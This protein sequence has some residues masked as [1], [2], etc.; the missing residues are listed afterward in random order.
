MVIKTIKT[1]NL[2]IIWEQ[3]DIAVL[4]S[5]YNF[6]VRDVLFDLDAAQTIDDLS[7]IGAVQFNPDNKNA[8][9][10]TIT[11]NNVEP[12]GAVLCD[13]WQGDCYNIELREYNA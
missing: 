3:D 6:Q 8:W 13:F 11:V 9:S 10:V 4:P 12:C 1:D 2:K 5:T 7:D